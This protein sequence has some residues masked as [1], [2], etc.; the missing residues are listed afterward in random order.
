MEKENAIQQVA[1]RSQI[2]RITAE[3]EMKETEKNRSSSVSRNVLRLTGHKRVNKS[4]K[5]MTYWLI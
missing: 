1:V 2:D 5:S 3:Y 4:R